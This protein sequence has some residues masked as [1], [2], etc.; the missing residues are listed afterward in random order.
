MPSIFSPLTVPSQDHLNLADA[1]QK[2]LAPIRGS[3]GQDVEVPMPTQRRRAR[4][5]YLTADANRMRGAEGSAP[6]LLRVFR[7]EL[8]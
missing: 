3:L 2:L 5:L 7:M 6:A 8:P 1:D 4:A